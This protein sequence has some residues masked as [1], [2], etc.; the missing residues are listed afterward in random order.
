MIG[1]TLRNDLR[2]NQATRARRSEVRRRK[3]TRRERI[4]RDARD[5]IE[6]LI[7][8]EEGLREVL[9]DLGVDEEREEEVEDMINKWGG[10]KRER[11]H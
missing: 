3:R 8:S 10:R 1:S 2:E 4:R 9:S 7:E 6:G 11:D 5:S